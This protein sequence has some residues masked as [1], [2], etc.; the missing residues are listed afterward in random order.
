[1]APIVNAYGAYMH[2]GEEMGVRYTNYPVLFPG[3]A[4]PDDLPAPVRLSRSTGRRRGDPVETEVMLL[5]PVPA[6][7]FVRAPRGL[8]PLDNGSEVYG[9]QVWSSGAFCRLLERQYTGE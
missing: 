5:T 3:G 2:Q 8:V 9:Y 7:L 4:F 1:M 6:Q